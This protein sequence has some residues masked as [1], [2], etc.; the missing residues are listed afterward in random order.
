MARAKKCKVWL[1]TQWGNTI[2]FGE[3]QSIK[4]AKEEIKFCELKNYHITL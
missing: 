2:F 3:F 1:T 4:K